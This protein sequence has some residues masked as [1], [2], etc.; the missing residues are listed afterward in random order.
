MSEQTWYER[1][2]GTVIRGSQMLDRNFKKY[3][4]V[5]CKAPTGGKEKAPAKKAPA[6]K[7]PT[8]PDELP[9]QGA[10]E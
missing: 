4:L 3:G 7:T 8:K 9:E 2:D 5:K 10:D 6:K 1:E